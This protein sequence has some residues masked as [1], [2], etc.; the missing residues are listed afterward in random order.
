[1]PAMEG[2]ATIARTRRVRPAWL[3]AVRDGAIVAGLL[4]AIYLFVVVAPAAGTFGFD[5]F[6]YWSVNPAHP[7]A[8][9]AGALGAF[10]YSPV[11]ARL[12]APF[13]ILPFWQFLWLW[14]AVLAA[15]VVWLG[16]RSAAAVLAFPP[17]ALE[18]YHGNVHLIIAA[19][20]VLGFRYPAAWA[21]VLL[22]KVTPGIGLVWFAA[23]REWRKVAIA[24]GVTAILV[25]I[26]MLV[27]GPRW[28][29]WLTDSLGATA[30][31]APLNQFSLPVPLWV[32]LPAAALL[33]AWGG[34]TDRAWTV[35]V[36]VTLALPVLWPTGFAVLA[37]LLPIAQRRPGLTDEASL[38]TA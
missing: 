23:R 9:T 14:T 19:A 30:S 12:F 6:A 26:S 11:M 5:A 36:G 18:L 29:E 3:R 34:R 20:I 22:T 35:P 31:G 33:V 1:M 15:T 37:A 7:Y 25:A 4:F 38:A 21:F 16:G 32:R 8:Q 28:R 10:T 24:L 17:V 27:D 2:A 13:G